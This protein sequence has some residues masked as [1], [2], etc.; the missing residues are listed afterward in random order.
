MV[1]ED[2][3]RRSE[4]AVRRLLHPR[5]LAIEPGR[6]LAPGDDVTLRWKPESAPWEGYDKSTYVHIYWPGDFSTQVRADDVEADDGVFRFTMPQVR[7]GRAK[8][9]LKLGYL[10]PRAEVLECDGADLCTAHVDLGSG[11]IGVE[12]VE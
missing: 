10:E 5:T 1:V 8:I 7:P 12:I 9:D 3:E 4:M 11:D 2:G 6:T